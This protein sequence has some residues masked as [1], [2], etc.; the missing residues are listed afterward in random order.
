MINII[1]TKKSDTINLEYIKSNDKDT[2]IVYEIE[3]NIKFLDE[4][5]YKV[6]D[7]FYFLLDKKVEISKDEFSKLVNIIKEI[8]NKYDPFG[9]A[10]VDEDEYLPEIID[11]AV[12]SLFKKDIYK[13]VK[14]TFESWFY[15]NGFDYREMAKEIEEIL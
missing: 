4:S 13:I 1:S 2:Y 15:D 14:N 9:I 5:L 12:L 7:K 8:V 10:F 3:K 11:I 6:G